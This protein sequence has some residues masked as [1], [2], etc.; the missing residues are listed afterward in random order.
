MAQ[1]D[2]GKVRLTDAELSE[3]IIQTN[4][5]VRFGRDADGKPGYVVTDAETGADT[6]IPFSNGS[7]GGIPVQG[8]ICFAGSK[9]HSVS[10]GSDYLA[11]VLFDDPIEISQ[12]KEIKTITQISNWYRISSGYTTSL[13][14]MMYIFLYIENN[15]GQFQQFRYSFP[16]IN[17]SGTGS[18]VA[19]E[20]EMI[21]PPSL[22]SQYKNLIGIGC[23]F[24]QY[25]GG[26]STGYWFTSQI[27]NA[28]DPHGSEMKYFIS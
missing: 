7:S 22:I 16:V 2:L 3:K 8:S 23:D 19:N 12:I 24:Y 5:G 20:K 27:G 17:V 9:I 13:S 15:D 21:I 25:G 10:G 4:G 26:S 11:F 1:A 28:A 18:G 14:R 6:V